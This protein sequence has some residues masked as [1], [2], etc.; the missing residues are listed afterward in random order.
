MYPLPSENKT[1]G[2]GCHDPESPRWFIWKRKNY[3]GWVFGPAKLV[4]VRD[5]AVTAG[6]R[7]QRLAWWLTPQE[8]VLAATVP[9][10]LCPAPRI[11]KFL[12][13]RNQNFIPGPQKWP[14]RNEDVICPHWLRVNGSG[15]EPIEPYGSRN[16]TG[17]G[18]FVLCWPFCVPCCGSLRSLPAHLCG[19]TG[20]VFMC[21][22]PCYYA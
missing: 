3:W 22:V 5:K 6:H 2:P 7:D 13:F 12:S 11:L 17:L 19:G 14:T 1:I 18:T 8:A 4:K 21:A 9:A 20:L 16:P 10:D 15:E